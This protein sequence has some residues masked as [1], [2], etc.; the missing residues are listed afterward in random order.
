MILCLASLAVMLF[1]QI[2]QG[3][4]AGSLM[5]I[6]IG[7][8]GLLARLRS[9]PLMLVLVLAGQQLLRHAGQSAQG[10]WWGAPEPSLDVTEVLLCGAVL[11][12]VVGH[13]RLQGLAYNIVPRDTTQPEQS[14]RWRLWPFGRRPAAVQDRR[15]E[16]AVSRVEVA[17][18]VMTLPAAPLL[19]QFL[20]MFLAR[21]WD[22]VG[23]PPRVGRTLLAG[24]LLAVGILVV[25]TVLR[26]WGH[27]R[28][29]PHSAAVLLQD[30]VWLETRREQR[31]INRWLAWA[32]LR[33]RPKE[34][35]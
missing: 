23:F 26:H 16:H 33:R 32:R 22:V 11:A 15:S 8:V 1:A 34:V 6:L 3:A 19:A 5:V 27:R 7:L 28:M 10:W 14:P 17:L 18:L 31:R 20:W 25:A 30:V 9:A 13:Y 24:W 21:P 35:S 12:Y 4:D 29:D 2:E